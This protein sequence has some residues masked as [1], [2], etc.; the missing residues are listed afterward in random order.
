MTGAELNLINYTR[1]S[2]TAV[3]SPCC[4]C[5]SLHHGWMKHGCAWNIDE[6]ML[7]SLISRAVGWCT[8]CICGRA[9]LATDFYY[10]LSWDSGDLISS[11]IAAG[12]N[13][14]LMPNSLCR[15]PPRRD[16]TVWSRRRPDLFAIFMSYFY[17]NGYG[18]VNWVTTSDR[19]PD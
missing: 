11:I 10:L 9:A 15:R 8:C 14:S 1:A 2:C 16:E 17:S 13:A 18:V 12:L 6:W 3:F 4:D 7:M 19:I 5:S